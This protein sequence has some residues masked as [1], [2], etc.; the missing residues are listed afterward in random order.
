[1]TIQEFRIT[2]K[3]RAAL[4]AMQ[5]NNKQDEEVP[6]HY[7][8]ADALAEAGLL[9]P[10][11][12]GE[13]MSYEYAVQYK[14]PDRWKYSRPSWENRWQDS[15]AVQEVRAHRDHP[16]Q[17]TRIVRRLVSTPEAMEE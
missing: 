4:I 1:M 3:G 7:R 15:E 8:I 2:N 16:G 13:A 5:E 9:A 10:G 6:A 17:E 12:G 14:T 11:P